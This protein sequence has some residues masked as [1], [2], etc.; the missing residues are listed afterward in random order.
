M[1]RWYDLPPEDVAE[2]TGTSVSNGLTSAEA[3][4]R[5]S[6]NGQNSVFPIP[7]DSFWSYMRKLST[8][9]LSI[10][11]AL[12]CILAAIFKQKEL[13]I[14]LLTTL[15]F[16]Y[17]AV[18]ASYMK[19]QKVFADT[20]RAA[21]PTAKVIRDG[22]IV[23]IRQENVVR[24]DIILISAGDIVPC[25]ARLIDDTN[26]V[27]IESGITEAPGPVHKDSSYINIRNVRPHEALNM[28]Y[29]STIVKSGHGKAI[30]CR[31]GKDCYV[32]T[33]GKNKP[34]VSCDK[35]AVFNTL[36]KLSFYISLVA[37]VTTFILTVFNM[38]PPFSRFDALDGL[39]YSLSYGC[40]AMTEFYAVFGYIIVAVGIFGS[41]SH[42]ER[43]SRGALIKNAEKLDKMRFLDTIIIPS[44]TISAKQEMSLECLY[45]DNDDDKIYHESD[46]TPDSSLA[47]LVRFG[48]ITTGIYGKRL[49]ALNSAGENI[50][51]CDEDAII[52]GARSHDL[53][54][55]YIDEEYPIR[56]HL[57]KNDYCPFETTLVRH[58][59]ENLV[60]VRGVVNEIL[61]VCG[62]YRD[63]KGHVRRMN[64]IAISRITTIASQMMRDYGTVIA[65]A[66][67][68]SIYTTLIRLSD[69]FSKMTFEGLL[70]FTE[71]IVPEAFHSI[72]KLKNAGMRVV[73]F[74]K[75]NSEKNISLAKSVGIVEEDSQI[76]SS[77]QIAEN[78]EDTL[79]QN[80]K[81][82]TLFLDMDAISERDVIRVMKKNKMNVG[83]LGLDFEEILPMKEA[84]IAFTQSV[85]VNANAPKKEKTDSESSKLPI[86][87]GKTSDGAPVGCDALRF[88]SDV[89]VS[90]AGSS[91]YNGGI[92]A[93]CQ[94]IER[95]MAT[96]NGIER[97]LRYLITVNS[98]KLLLLLVT[99]I[100]G[101]SMLTPAQMLIAGQIFDLASV[102]IIAFEKPGRDILKKRPTKRWIDKPIK[103]NI[104]PL[105]LGVILGILE[106]ATAII[107][108]STGLVGKSTAVTPV[109][110][111]TLLSVPVILLESSRS[112]RLSEGN[113]TVSNMFLT[114]VAAIILTIACGL[115]FP[116]FGKLL[117][118]YR[119]HYA[120]ILGSVIA[121]AL[122]LLI[123]ELFKKRKAQK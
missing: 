69:T 15:I 26:L 119:V 19:A 75:D 33:I 97:L 49:V 31:T 83:Y 88:T 1:K 89:I 72:E 40:G 11:L 82:Y 27:V 123:C 60:Y 117:G 106:I 74:A 63:V 8:N 105:I 2:K 99:F 76:I 51:S 6:E 17:V 16:N 80:L 28:V 47:D 84:D 121:P 114:A 79:S 12:C 34:V 53:Y 25:D 87:V 93:V 73:L 20:G 9:T 104:M 91:D 66:S 58:S 37:I 46:I 38:L 111:S 120:A 98:A 96:F 18:I 44:E 55:R 10:L 77:A 103:A 94:S 41:T 43:I 108:I 54:N 100:T 101:I 14:T 90:V 115:I 13:A 3:A 113:L 56:E 62:E 71:P 110:I 109:F 23:L 32:C 50:Y 81:N 85:T 57:G 116:V 30:A 22:R 86:T 92:N 118:I 68:K 61:S 36:H 29:A 64:Q 112:N 52:S 78:G 67:K 65:I 39:L 102:M 95:A 7:V 24:G 70:G 5:L 4:K 59:D 107:L 21:I 42:R 35:L 45:I 48:V 122:L